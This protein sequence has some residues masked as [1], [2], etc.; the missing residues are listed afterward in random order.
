MDGRSDERWLTRNRAGYLVAALLLGAAVVGNLEHR[1]IPA[2]D[3][4]LSALPTQIG[5]WKMVDE[6]VRNEPD[7]SYQTLSRTY[8]ASGGAKMH[9]T[10]Q[11][12]RTRLGSLR[13]WSL[14]A[15]AQGWTP[16]EETVWRSPDGVMEARIQRLV[17][18]SDARIALTWYTSASSQGPSLKSAEMLGARDRLLGDR[19]PWASLYVIA[20]EG[21]QEA[22][23][24]AIVE[25]AAALGPPLRQIMTQS[26]LG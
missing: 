2:D 21:H 20:D 14:A 6:D 4:A 5:Q 17:S 12:T 1:T 24:T 16:A 19:R 18:K 7:G 23:R 10:V 9:L 25:L 13:D 3:I 22:D 11:A 15:M 26:D 8:Q